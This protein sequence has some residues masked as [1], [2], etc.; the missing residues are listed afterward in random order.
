M[1]RD[2]RINVV[3][4]STKAWNGMDGYTKQHNAGNKVF[5]WYEV[6]MMRKTR[7]T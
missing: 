1:G 3:M 6:C 2:G 4:V 5:C 7:G